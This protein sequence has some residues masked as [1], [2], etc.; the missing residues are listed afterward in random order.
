MRLC[1]VHTVVVTD[2]GAE[3]GV[4]AY[5]RKSSNTE[6]EPEDILFT[7]L[8]I[9]WGDTTFVDFALDDGNS[10]WV[11]LCKVIRMKGRSDD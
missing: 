6:K 10:V 2:E 7:K 4:R 3:Y 8:G 5:K 9:E 11:P 1:D